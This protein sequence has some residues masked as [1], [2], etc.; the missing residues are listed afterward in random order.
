MWILLVYNP[1][2]VNLK[3]FGEN[4]VQAH[5]SIIERGTIIADRYGIEKYLGESLLG[6][7]YVLIKRLTIKNY[8][9]SS[10]YEKYKRVE[11]EE[12]V[13]ELMNRARLVVHDHVVR[14]GNVG[15]YEDMIYFTQ[16]YFPSVNLLQLTLEYSQRISSFPLGK[17]CLL[18]EKVLPSIYH[19][20]INKRIIHTN[21]KPENILIRTKV[22][23]DRLVREVKILIL[24]RHLLLVKIILSQV[25]IVLQNVVQS[26]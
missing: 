7:T 23:N 16:E 17:A 20:Y 4:C 26:I 12:E 13:R 5:S 11:D 19:L 6:P 9:H 3:N 21:I 10:L 25:I 24:W 18:V 22:E 1:I 15:I 8:W 2:N 14:Y